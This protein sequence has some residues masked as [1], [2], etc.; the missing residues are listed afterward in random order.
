MNQSK[1]MYRKRVC[2]LYLDPELQHIVDVLR[3]YLYQLSKNSDGKNVT[4]QNK[5]YTEK[6][7]S[8]WIDYYFFNIRTRNKNF[9]E[10]SVLRKVNFCPTFSYFLYIRNFTVT[11]KNESEVVGKKIQVCTLYKHVLKL[12]ILKS[13][14]GYRCFP[15]D[16]VLR[17][18][19]T[20]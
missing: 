17:V 7:F 1:G 18:F 12:A 16:C 6:F 9:Q 4:S 5:H 20:S 2:Y 10:P 13:F 8:G 11:S 3:I 15:P 14:K 19:G